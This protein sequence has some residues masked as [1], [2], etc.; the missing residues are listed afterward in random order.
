MD[1]I[2]R[3]ALPSDVN[4]MIPLIYMSGSIPSGGNL[5]EIL[6]GLA[7]QEVY[8]LLSHLF[9]AKTSCWLHHSVFYVAEIDQSIAA[10]TCAYLESEN[11]VESMIGALIECGW[12]DK[13]FSTLSRVGTIFNR[14]MVERLEARVCGYAF[15]V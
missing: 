13:D 7:K 12:K 9:N 2:F 1:P 8:D 3:P 5:F 15:S 11:G 6:F 4:E 14:V 10:I